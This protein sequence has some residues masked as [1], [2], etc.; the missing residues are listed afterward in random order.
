MIAAKKIYAGDGI[1]KALF[2][3]SR[4]LRA[5]FLPLLSFLFPRVFFQGKKRLFPKLLSFV[6]KEGSFEPMS[7]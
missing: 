4:N 2:P 3:L 1:F 6:K 5:F 7:P